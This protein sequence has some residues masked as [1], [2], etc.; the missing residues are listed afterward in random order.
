[1]LLFLF[2]FTPMSLEVEVQF[3]LGGL[4]G[5]RVARSRR[6]RSRFSGKLFTPSGI[7]APSVII[8]FCICEMQAR[9]GAGLVIMSSVG[10][11]LLDQTKFQEE[12]TLFTYF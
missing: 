8:A 3:S 2:A 7:G 11:S 4:Q 5:Q 12:T 1:M 10:F 6:Q 9:I